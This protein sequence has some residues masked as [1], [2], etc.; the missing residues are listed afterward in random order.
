MTPVPA[1]HALAG[2]ERLTL[3]EVCAD[4]LVAL[5]VGAGIRTAFDRACAAAGT[6]SDVAWEVT[7]PRAVGE[8]VRA[9]F[10]VAVLREAVATALDLVPLGVVDLDQRADLLLVRRPQPSPAVRQ[11]LRACEATSTGAAPRSAG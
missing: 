7:A 4:P 3:G 9:G 8:L 6:T 2:R 11:L 10:G 1:G 5:P